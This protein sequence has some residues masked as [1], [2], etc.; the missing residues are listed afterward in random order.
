MFIESIRRGVGA[1]LL[2]AAL[3]FGASV[4]VGHAEPDPQLGQS[5]STPS[6][7]VVSDRNGGPTLVC[8]NGRWGILGPVL[9]TSDLAEIGAACHAAPTFLAMGVEPQRWPGIFLASC[10]GGVWTVFRP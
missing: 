6:G 1:A 8:A 5:C 9:G 3:A 7:L 4:G 10:Q 2:A